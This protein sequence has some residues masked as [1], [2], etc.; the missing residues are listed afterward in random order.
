MKSTT[1][2]RSVSRLFHESSTRCATATAKRSRQT[3]AR[4]SGFAPPTIAAANTASPTKITNDDAS[5]DSSAPPRFSAIAGLRRPA[6][7]FRGRK[8]GIVW[9]YR[10]DAWAEVLEH[11][12]EAGH[13]CHDGEE[14]DDRQR[15]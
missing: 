7:E 1:R 4:T 14:D 5:G 2:I 12:G 9:D 13:A 6:D 10:A 11:G 3:G 15:L 8:L